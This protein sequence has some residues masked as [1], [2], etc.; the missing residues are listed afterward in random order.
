MWLFSCLS[1]AHFTSSFFILFNL[2]C[3]GQSCY[4]LLS[5]VSAEWPWLTGCCVCVCYSTPSDINSL[6]L[7]H[8]THSKY[9]QQSKDSEWMCV[10]LPLTPSVPLYLLSLFF[11]QSKIFRPTVSC[12]LASGQ[13]RGSHALS[14]ILRIK[15]WI[16]SVGSFVFAC[17]H[18]CKTLMPDG[19]FEIDC[20]YNND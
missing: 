16:R 4:I 3:A 20:F 11:S 2:A 17:W 13:A 12:Y 7:Y 6:D 14:T 8:N 18:D 10:F 19:S 5:Q 15:C 1:G 9:I